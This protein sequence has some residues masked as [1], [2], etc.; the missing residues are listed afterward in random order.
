VLWLAS[1]FA[2]VFA[3]AST[4]AI[5]TLDAELFPTEVRGTSNSLLLVCGVAGSVVGLLVA[6]FLSGPLGGL[7]GSIA[8]CGAAPF[9]AALFLAPRLPESAH[10]GL[11]DV[12]PSEV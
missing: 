5:G 11:D 8:L 2:I 1:T 9:A 4:L 7:G 6:G 12:S 10:R 3:G